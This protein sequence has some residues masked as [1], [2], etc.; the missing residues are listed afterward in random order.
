MHSTYMNLTFKAHTASSPVK[1]NGDNHTALLSGGD[2]SAIVSRC[3]FSRTPDGSAENK[4]N[5]IHVHTESNVI[6]KTEKVL[7]F[8]LT[9][10]NSANG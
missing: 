1:T 8:P 2:M 9:Q 3:T 7:L 10:L 5:I 4:P 6:N